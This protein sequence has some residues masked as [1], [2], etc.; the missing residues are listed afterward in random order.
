MVTKV[1][2]VEPKDLYYLYSDAL[3][4]CRIELLS[5]DDETIE[6]EIFEEFD[7]EAVSF[8]HPEALMKLFQSGYISEEK[9]KKSEQL[10]ELV[11]SLRENEEWSLESFRHSKNWV[12]VLEMAEQIRRLK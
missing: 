6:Y 11:D 9:M 4:R 7:I 8:L 2:E 3:N 12:A 10:R 5:A 1:R